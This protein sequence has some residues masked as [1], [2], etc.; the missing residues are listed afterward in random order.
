MDRKLGHWDIPEKLFSLV[1]YL[2]HGSDSVNWGTDIYDH[3]KKWIGRASDE[4][5]SGTIFIAGP[6]SWHG[7]LMEINYV[8]P[9]WIRR[10]QLS[11][12]DH[13][14]SLS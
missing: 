13:P 5:D 14:I 7:R 9:N 12:P 1:I 11:F 6:Y 3:D 8:R 10:E 4:F 2:F